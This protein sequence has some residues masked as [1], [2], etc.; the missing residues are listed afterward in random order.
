MPYNTTELERDLALSLG[1]PMY[2]ADPRLAELGSKTGCRRLFGEVGVQYPIGAED[3]RDQ[4]TWSR[5]SARHAP[6]ASGLSSVI[7]KLNEG[8]RA[9]GTRRRPVRAPGGGAA[10]GEQVL[11]RVMQMQLESTTTTLETYLASFAEMG[12]IVEERIVG[13]EIRSPSV[14]LRVTPAGVVELLSTHD[15]LL[16]GASGQSYLGC[17]FPADPGYARTDRRRG[18]GGR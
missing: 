17:A 14:Q 12:G 1:I 9:G 10:A 8:C 3:V 7:V 15:Q 6:P 13:E 5:R 4:T 11:Q 2:G 16:G 18:A